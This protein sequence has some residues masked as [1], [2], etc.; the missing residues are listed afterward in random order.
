MTW[1]TLRHRAEAIGFFLTY[2]SAATPGGG[3]APDIASP[4]PGSDWQCVGV[5][6]Q[7][8][9]LW[10]H[11][12]T[13]AARQMSRDLLTTMLG[14]CDRYVEPLPNLDAELLAACRAQ[15][16]AVEHPEWVRMPA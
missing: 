7:L 3:Y 6:G 5:Y 1:S 2:R 16:T 14:N 12:V 4:P 8:A 10:V 11:P 9:G 13:P 15:G